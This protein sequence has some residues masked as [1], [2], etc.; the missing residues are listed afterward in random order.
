MALG[1]QKISKSRQD[2]RTNH[3]DHQKLSLYLLFS[4]DLALDPVICRL[5]LKFWQQVLSSAFLAKTGIERQ[6]YNLA[7][8]QNCKL[9][10]W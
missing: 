4:A 3:V 2:Q 6:A 9:Y 8:H 10:L 5:H 1:I 7:T